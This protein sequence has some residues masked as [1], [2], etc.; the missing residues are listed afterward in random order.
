MKGLETSTSF[1]STC[2]GK[3]GVQLSAAKLLRQ[4]RINKAF[5]IQT[6]NPSV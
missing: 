5:G 6:R 3:S 2:H 1:I 4:M